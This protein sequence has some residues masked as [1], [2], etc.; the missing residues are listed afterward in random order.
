MPELKA[1]V[2]D[3]D[4]TLID[5]NQAFRLFLE[6][7][8]A[9]HQKN[10]SKKDWKNIEKQDQQGY[11]QR[12]IFTKWF[13]NY[14]KLKDL[15]PEAFW[16][17][18]QQHLG[19]FVECVSSVKECLRVLNE[20]YKLCL[21]TNG[22]SQNQ[23]AK[24]HSA[25]LDNFFEKD[26]IFISGEMG[27]AKPST[28]AFER[29]L[30]KTKTNPVETLMVGD[31]FINDILPARKLGMKTCWITSKPESGIQHTDYCLPHVGRLAEILKKK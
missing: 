1:I 8:L 27:F 6:D 22:G 13:L 10:I 9:R 23:R 29:V 24:I 4:N 26:K 19:N 28:E 21:L 17:Y 11:A 14:Y 7:F 30:A 3:L 25:G 31:H 2:F 16:Q 5:R 18:M 15:S 12:L 20:N